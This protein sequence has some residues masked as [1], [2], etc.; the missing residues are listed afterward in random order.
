MRGKYLLIMWAVFLTVMGFYLLNTRTIDSIVDLD[1]QESLKPTI[2]IT[3]KETRGGDGPSKSS[4]DIKDVEEIIAYLKEFEFRKPF[5]VNYDTIDQVGPSYDI[6]I[7]D[8][9][10]EVL[11]ACIAGDKFLSM[12]DKKGTWRNYIPKND[13]LFDFNYLDNFYETL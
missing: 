12:N 8:S 9:S 2:T 1:I 5:R 10:G 3:Q 6:L 11:K 4:S 13:K 7:E